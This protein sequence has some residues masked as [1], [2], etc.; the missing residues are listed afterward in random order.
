MKRYLSKI[1]LWER[2]SHSISYVG[3][4]FPCVLAPLHHVC[5]RYVVVHIILPTA[6]GLGFHNT[7]IAK[8]LPLSC[9]LLCTFSIDDIT[10]IM[11][12]DYAVC[13]IMWVD[14]GVGWGLG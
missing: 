12:N 4:P 1:L 11:A 6:S 3:T 13:V 5:A 14:G 9:V 2:R 8:S 10:I 7:C